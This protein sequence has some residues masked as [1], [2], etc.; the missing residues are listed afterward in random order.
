MVF[1]YNSWLFLNGFLIEAGVHGSGVDF[2][3]IP[4][5]KCLYPFNISF[6]A[7]SPAGS[8][9]ALCITHCCYFVLEHCGYSPCRWRC[10]F[11]LPPPPTTRHLLHDLYFSILHLPPRLLY[12]VCDV[13]LFAD[14][15]C[16]FAY[17]VAWVAFWRICVVSIYDDFNSF[18]NFTMLLRYAEGSTFTATFN[19]FTVHLLGTDSIMGCGI[20]PPRKSRFKSIN[21]VFFGFSSLGD[22]RAKRTMCFGSLLLPV[23]GRAATLCAFTALCIPAV[24]KRVFIY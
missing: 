18:Y 14:C 4:F 24:Y 2:L 6:V 13:L 9:T 5:P 8:G 11:G 17:N 10:W 22:I 1:T 20:T 16:W 19:D 23:A 12:D 21:N 15:Q 7:H 3:V